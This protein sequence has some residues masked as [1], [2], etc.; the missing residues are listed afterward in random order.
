[1]PEKKEVS[2][3]YREVYGAVTKSLSLRVSYVTTLVSALT[4]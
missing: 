2:P 1:M 4:W 3:G